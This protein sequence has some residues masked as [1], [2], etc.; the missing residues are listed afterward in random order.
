MAQET[1]LVLTLSS[2]R[3]FASPRTLVGAWQ[4]WCSVIWWGKSQWAPL[5][6][7]DLAHCEAEWLMIRMSVLGSL[8]PARNL[9]LAGP[10]LGATS[11]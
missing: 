4:G 9:H 3:A 11:K 10:W 7:V 1:K 8:G 6:A 5:S 2:K